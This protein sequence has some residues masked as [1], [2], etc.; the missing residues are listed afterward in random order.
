MMWS[1]SIRLALGFQGRKHRYVA[2]YGLPGDFRWNKKEE[3]SNYLKVF[4]IR[5]DVWN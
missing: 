5:V 2:E 1:Y 3:S 4:T